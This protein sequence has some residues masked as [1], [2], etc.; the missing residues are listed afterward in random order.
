VL[1]WGPKRSF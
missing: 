1:L